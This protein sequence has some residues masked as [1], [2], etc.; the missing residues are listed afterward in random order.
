MGAVG[1]LLQ[2]G[3]LTQFFVPGSQ[4]A[5]TASDKNIIPISDLASKNR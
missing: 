5:R 1:A 3:V 4:S 2:R